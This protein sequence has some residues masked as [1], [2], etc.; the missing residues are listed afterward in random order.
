MTKAG[1]SGGAGKPIDINAV[2]IV[3]RITLGLLGVAGFLACSLLGGTGRITG[4]SGLHEIIEGVG[5][6]L[7]VVAIAGRTWCSL[8]IGG[9]KKCFVVQDGPYSNLPQPT[10]RLLLIGAAGVGAQFGAG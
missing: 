9:R 1:N 6:V 4:G 7:I 5:L 3:R 8:Y 2:Q 10:L